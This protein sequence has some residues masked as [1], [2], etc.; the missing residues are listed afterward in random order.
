M[1]EGAASLS[2]AELEVRMSVA[3]NIEH[4]NDI[5]GMASVRYL[6]SILL[7]I[8]SSHCRLLMWDQVSIGHLS[9]L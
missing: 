6:E 4:Y 7:H 5:R 1:G 2:C 3:C 8:L 9:K